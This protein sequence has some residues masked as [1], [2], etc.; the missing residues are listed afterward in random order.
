V[1]LS[2]WLVSL[3]ALVL[4][5]VTLNHWV[6]LQSLPLV[7]TVTGWDW[8][9]GPL[10]WRL[11]FLAPLFLVLTSPFRLLPVAWQPVALNA[12]TAVCAAAT[13]G[14][15]AASVRLLPH[16]RTREQRGRE[17]G[18]FAL[19]SLRTAYLPALFAVLLLG[20]Q[21][22][23]WKNA[24][25]ATGEMVDVLVFAFLIFCLLRFRVTQNDRWLLVS[26]F[27]YGLGMANN[28]AM[29]GFFPLFIVATI[30]TKG[31]ASFNLRFIGLISAC[32]AAGLS[33]CLLV[34]LL[35]MLGPNHENF[36][37]VL[38]EQLGVERFYLRLV[39]HW[40]VAVAALPTLL[41]LIFAGIRWPS[42]E[43]DISAA[44]NMLNRMMFNFLHVIFLALA[45]VTFFDV[46]YSPNVLMRQMPIS[47]LTFYYAAALAVGY[48]TGYVLLVF[49]KKPLRSWD[50]QGL[51]KTAANDLLVGL[52]CLAAVAAPAFLFWENW[53]HIRSANSPALAQIADLIVARLPADHALVL[54]DDPSRL[55]L[56][57]AAY[58]RQ[59]L[60]EKN[61]LI[62]SES[63][64]HREYIRSLLSRYA[65][66][67]KV[68][69]PPEHLARVIPPAS[70]VDFMYR[71]NA[72]YPIFYLHPSFGYYFEAFYMRPSGLVYELHRY[73]NTLAQPLSSQSPELK[74]NQ[75]FWANLQKGVLPSLP[76]MEQAD[77]DA[78]AVRIDYSVALDYWGTELQKANLFKEAG[79]KFAEAV[80]LDTNNY[81]ARINY[82][83]NRQ[84]QQGNRAPVDSADL[85][86]KAESLY[87]GFVRVIKNNGP[88]DEPNLDLEWGEA[89][90]QGGSLRQAAL[91]FERRL[92]LL[93][94]DGE[95]QLAMAKTYV[96]LRQPER[97]LSLVRDLRLAGKID[98]WQLTRV[99]A[100]AYLSQRDYPSAVKLLQ[101]AIQE[102]PGDG[103]RL[104]TLAEIYR[105]EGY[106]LLHAR[107]GPQA[108]YYF[109]NALTNLDR[110]LQLLSSDNMSDAQTY[111]RAEVLLKKAELQMMLRD[112]TGAVATLNQIL[113][114]QPSNST[115][116]LNRSIAEVQLK[117]METAKEDLKALRKLM[118]DQ[119]YIADYGLADIATE[120]KNTA[121]EIRY[122]RSYL[123]T[124]P[125]DNSEY[126][127]VTHR[128]AKLEGH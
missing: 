9:P 7:A 53:P 59:G 101:T 19:L 46:K 55:Y 56:L 21:L 12:F 23:F 8:H 103:T 41:P 14:L 39:P 50:R 108:A 57:E 82:D 78:T 31:I 119:P 47:F 104:S 28:W 115:A 74:E 99:E 123:K 37:T 42:F 15:L 126:L 94:G 33:L 118:P 70:L 44:S 60:H 87:G 30:W 120:E 112:F 66:L 117:Q 3:G 85:L 10:P 25:V 111:A 38:H 51:V 121:D 18:A 89:L 98:P 4:Y 1:I 102:N 22:T 43:G 80:R 110:H 34:P 2:P 100:L 67:K 93:P 58:D 29:I 62:N 90:A 77:Q 116:L 79:E 127:Q 5:G 124:A 17:Q 13:L 88:A 24:V 107:K 72:Q 64:S 36:W 92:Q 83:Y 35:G 27:V 71:M 81:I 91:L 114:L 96:D 61:I 113:Q 68:M 32:G 128:L 65:E 20:L 109:Q 86:Y 16:D 63:F 105:V 106:E 75:A 97:A 125:D 6:T 84:F 48:F 52:V 76:P 69:T 122:L 73:T 11:Q 95:A 26:A 40:V 45:L 54:S 49:G